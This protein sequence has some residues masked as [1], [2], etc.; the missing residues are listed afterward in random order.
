VI[1]GDAG[2]DFLAGGFDNDVINGGTGDD[3]LAGEL[4]PGSEAPPVSP[5]AATR[6]ICVGAAGFDVAL[7]CD[8]TAATEA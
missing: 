3:F 6:D 1:N 7:E 2:D 8:I 4:P 5:P